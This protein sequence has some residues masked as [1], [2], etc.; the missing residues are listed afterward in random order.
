MPGV[1]V[2]VGLVTASE[3][4]YLGVKLLKD[5]YNQFKCEINN[6]HEFDQFYVIV[7]T[8][9]HSKKVQQ[10]CEYSHYSFA[11]APEVRTIVCTPILCA[12]GNPNSHTYI[13]LNRHFKGSSNIS[14]I[15]IL[16]KNVYTTKFKL[17][18]L[19]LLILT[20]SVFQYSV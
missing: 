17:G 5:V 2:G 4:I 15:Q 6:L 1:G 16:G 10:K 18:I 12:N 19:L 3:R 7:C 11:L 13:E 9:S 20:I 8:Y 14:L